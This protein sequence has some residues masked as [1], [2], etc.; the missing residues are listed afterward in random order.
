MMP[1]TGGHERATHYQGLPCTPFL[2]QSLNWNTHSKPA[3]SARADS[4]IFLAR[5]RK[6]VGALGFGAKTYVFPHLPFPHGR[7]PGLLH[8][9]PCRLPPYPVTG[10]K[11]TGLEWGC[12]AGLLPP[13]RSRAFLLKKWS[14]DQQVVRNAQSWSCP[15]NKRFPELESAFL[16]DAQVLCAHMTV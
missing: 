3:A 5:N 7:D 11:S 9:A 13:H 6:R 2:T 4:S 14:V 12:L 8:T 15:P 10:C 1:H 16:Q